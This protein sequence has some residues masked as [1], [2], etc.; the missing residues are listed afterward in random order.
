M[1][2]NIM[3][4]NNLLPNKNTEFSFYKPQ[5]QNILLTRDINLPEVHKLV[6][7]D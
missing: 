4:A 1:K 5:I 3:G 2:Q 6:T 7:S